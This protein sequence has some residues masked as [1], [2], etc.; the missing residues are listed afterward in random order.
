MPG[1]GFLI[2]RYPLVSGGTSFPDSSTTAASTPGIALGAEPGF[3]GMVSRPGNGDRIAPPVSVCHHVSTIG[4]FSLPM[5]LKYHI[6]T[7][8]LVDSPTVPNNR[9]VDKLNEFRISLPYL[10]YI[11]SAVGVVYKIVIPRSEE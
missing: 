7:S 10:I 3:S 5:V 8:G 6:H 2:T 1:Q 9:R 11:L 4:H